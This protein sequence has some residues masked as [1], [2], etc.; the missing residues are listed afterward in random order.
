[1]RFGVPRPTAVRCGIFVPFE[2]RLAVQR[3]AIL[4]SA[5]VVTAITSPALCCPVSSRLFVERMTEP[6][7]RVLHVR[8][9]FWSIT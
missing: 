2:A 9:I 6:I 4:P 1:M 7:K 5:I 3:R 8:L